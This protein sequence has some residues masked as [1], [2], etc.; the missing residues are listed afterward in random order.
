[1][2][3]NRK[4]GGSPP[5]CVPLHS[6][7]VTDSYFWSGVGSR[8]GAVAPRLGEELCSLVE[9]PNSIGQSVSGGSRTRKRPVRCRG[10]G[11]YFDR[12]KHDRRLQPQQR[13]A[14]EARTYGRFDE[15]PF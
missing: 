12:R 2:T 8:L 15:R 11:R 7:R 13:N 14:Q 10:R 5:D 6:P 3:I 9:A 4:L 1:V